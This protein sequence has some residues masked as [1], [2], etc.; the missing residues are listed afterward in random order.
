MFGG[1]ALV[2][3][4]ALGF[5]LSASASDF[6]IVI[7]EIFYNPWTDEDRDEFVELYNAGAA[8]VDLSGWSFSEGIKFTFPPGAALG[9][10]DYL[11]LS[12]DSARAALHYR[13][14]NVLGNYTGKLDNNGEV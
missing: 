1:R 11:V 9:P 6:D 5:P 13:I 2:L 14:A 10:D 3:A 7:N 4:V 8:A 12:P